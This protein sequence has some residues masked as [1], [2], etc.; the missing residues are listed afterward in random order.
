MDVQGI[1]GF[2]RIQTKGAEYLTFHFCSFSLVPKNDV[3]RQCIVRGAKYSKSRVFVK[4]G[5]LEFTELLRYF[6]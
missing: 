3:I 4:I 6:S 5:I 1:F 2:A